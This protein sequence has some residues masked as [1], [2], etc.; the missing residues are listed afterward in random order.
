MWL[1]WHV[2]TQWHSVFFFFSF[3]PF[4]M[5]KLWPMRNPHLKVGQDL[6]KIYT[7]IDRQMMFV[8]HSFS[9]TQTLLLCQF[10]EIL[11]SFLTHFYW[12]LGTFYSVSFGEQRAK[13]ANSCQWWTKYSMW[14]SGIVL[15]SNARCRFSWLTLNRAEVTALIQREH[16]RN[17][18]HF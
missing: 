13:P 6:I 14:R 16:W 17:T 12:H 5:S 9:C 2:I 7:M 15:V 3:L 10:Q 8:T 1:E 4:N 11:L 18:G